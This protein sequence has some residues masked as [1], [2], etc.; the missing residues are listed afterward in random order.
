MLGSLSELCKSSKNPTDIVH[1]VDVHYCFILV[2]SSSQHQFG[3]WVK[4][5]PVLW[6]YQ[7]EGVTSSF[8]MACK[9]Q[10]LCPASPHFNIC[11]LF[12]S[13]N[14]SYLK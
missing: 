14:F 7:K 13:Y 8:Y 9:S 2:F 3:V 6:A 10:P 1:T 5:F 12:P 11:I 4:F